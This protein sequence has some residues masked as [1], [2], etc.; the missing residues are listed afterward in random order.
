MSFEDILSYRPKNLEDIEDEDAQSAKRAAGDDGGQPRAKRSQLDEEGRAALEALDNDDGPL[1]SFDQT[2][3]KKLALSLQRKVSANQ[4]MRIKHP[5]DPM[6]FMDSEVEL[7]GELGNFS[8]AATAPQYYHVLVKS[9]VAATLIGLM[10]HENSDISAAAI[11]V[12]Q[13]LTDTEALE[14]DMEATTGFIDSLLEQELFEQLLPLLSRFDES[15]VEEAKA[16]HDAQSI[17]ENMLE[18][19]P[20]LVESL[21][22]DTDLLTWLIKRLEVPRRLLHAHPQGLREL[23]FVSSF[24]DQAPEFDANKLYVSE[25]LAVL[26]QTS[27]ANRQKLGQLNGIEGLLQT[28]AMYK[29][30]DPSTEEE[31]EMLE[32]CFDVLCS[33][34]MEEGNK[35]T[36][37]NCE[38]VELMILLLRKKQSAR[39]GGL[40]VLDFVLMGGPASQRAAVTVVDKLGL[41]SIFPAFMKVPKAKKRSAIKGNEAKYEEHIVNIVASLF[42]ELRTHDYYE[43]LLGKFVESNLAKTVRLAELHANYA[44]SLA[45]CDK[46]IHFELK[47]MQEDG[48][49]I[50]ED[51]LSGHYLRR[52]DSGLSVLQNVDYIVA[53]VIHGCQGEMREEVEKLFKIKGGKFE[54]VASILKD[55]AENIGDHDAGEDSFARR[56]EQITKAVS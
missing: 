33:C 32:N 45:K 47:V 23:E 16:V 30:S 7:H 50:D 25:L 38:G 55:Y 19:K 22:K 24:P 9:K 46:E 4:K 3:M 6:K 39:F 5:D 11:T 35:E 43:R 8:L 37:L 15:N 21:V 12:L 14:E 53:E 48:M 36:F 34:L 44:T 27:E 2:A 56:V 29:R 1:V 42:R 26:V 51:V 20:E 41:K 40:R 10:N 17:I 28:I 52:L 18:L 49:E 13:E 54:Q 31:G